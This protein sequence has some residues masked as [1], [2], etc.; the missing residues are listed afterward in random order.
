METMNNGELD[1]VV[2]GQT[3]KTP[4]AEIPVLPAL[5]RNQSIHVEGQKTCPARSHRRKCL[6]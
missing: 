3:D 2:A 4:R 1:M 5:T 6:T